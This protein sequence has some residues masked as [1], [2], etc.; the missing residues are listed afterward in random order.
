MR[1]IICSILLIV[2]ISSLGWSQCG[3]DGSYE[4]PY[5]RED[6]LKEESLT[7]RNVA[8]VDIRLTVWIVKDDNGNGALINGDVINI[9]DDVVTVFSS[10]DINISPCIKQLNDT[11]RFNS[12][13]GQER[14]YNSDCS[15][16]SFQL[17]IYED[18]AGVNTGQGEINGTTAWAIDDYGTIVHELGHLFGLKHTFNQCCP[19]DEN[20]NCL[21]P[22]GLS[23]CMEHYCSDNSSENLSDYLIDY[24]DFICDTPAIPF[25]A[26]ENTI[27][28]TD[29]DG[30]P[31]NCNCLLVAYAGE[32]CAATIY[33]DFGFKDRCG[34]EF[35]D[36]T[37]NGVV[38]NFMSYYNSCPSTFSNGQRLKM[39]HDIASFNSNKMGTFNSCDFEIVSGLLAGNIIDQ[40]LEF[41]DQ[42]INFSNSLNLINSKVVFKNCNITFDGPPLEIRSIFLTDSKI[43]LDGTSIEA[44]DDCG[45]EFLGIEAVDGGNSHIRIWNNSHLKAA[46]PIVNYGAQKLFL[47]GGDEFTIE[48]TRGTAVDAKNPML[49]FCDGGNFLGNIEYSDDDVTGYYSSY[50]LVLRD[51][52][53]THASGGGKKAGLSLGGASFALWNT[54][55]EEFDQA[56]V[57][58]EAADVVVDGCLLESRTSIQRPGVNIST[59]LTATI[60]NNHILGSGISLTEVNAM[61]EL[62]RNNLSECNGSCTEKVFLNGSNSG[63]VINHNIIDSQGNGLK[64]SGESQA[65]F[66]CNKFENSPSEN[67]NWEGVN[68]LQGYDFNI[69]SGNIFSDGTANQISGLSPD[70]VQYNYSDN[71]DEELNNYTNISIDPILVNDEA[72]CG[73]IGPSWVLSGTG[74]D[75]PDGIDCTQPCPTGIDCTMDCPAGIDCTEPCPTG[76]DCGPD[77]PLGID[78]TTYCPR[79]ID[80][81]QDCP[82]GI[83]CTQDCPAGI[84]CT[85]PCPLGVDCFVNCPPGTDCFVHCP[86]LKDCEPVVPSDD[87]I[88]ELIDQSF[89]SLEGQRNQINGRLYNTTAE[90]QLLLAD[91]V[92]E[93]RSLIDLSKRVEKSISPKDMISVIDHSRIYTKEEFIE[94]VIHNPVNLFNNKINNVIFSSK[95]FEPDDLNALTEAMNTLSSVEMSDL[96]SLKKID[97]EKDE[98]VSYALDRI[99]AY[100]KGGKKFLPLWLGRLNDL[101]SIIQQIRLDVEMNEMNNINS[102][103]SEAYRSDLSS[104]ELMD[105]ETYVALFDLL[106]SADNAGRKLD[107]LNSNELTYL[108]NLSRS[109]HKYTRAKAQSILSKFYEEDFDQNEYRMSRPDRLE[110]LQ[111]QTTDVIDYL[112][113]NV[114]IYPNPSKNELSILTD[115]PIENIMV[116]DVNGRLYHPSIDRNTINILSMLPGVYFLRFQLNGKE[117]TKKFIKI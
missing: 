11:Q 105:M 86:N 3:T 56:I 107:D 75:C 52:K 5:S 40:D 60:N 90:M 62:S 70:Q 44:A 42:T 31:D 9:I 53:L 101:E 25:P 38:T 87:P 97:Q 36:P 54:S 1:K 91:Q 20:F 7:K 111:T 102:I 79:G 95:S 17:T 8:D 50:G 103:K 73:K 27:T 47:F 57:S 21:I 23:E 63:H 24:G 96:W 66:L 114:N 94:L 34:E 55:I 29:N 88:L 84:D 92:S 30:L 4:N 113:E 14:F 74:G 67:F 12:Q 83:D 85:E 72:N 81:T 22:N 37:G 93:K 51:S 100:G 117:Y 18:Q 13:N 68:L 19:R 39:L 16:S 78:C 99:N 48:A 109:E 104:T 26:A 108:R 45:A 115:Q 46:F 49:V 35:Y 28:C 59:P 33:R 76:I 82:P 110:F 58:S 41:V 80:C 116:T 77:C 10:Y 69:A 2:L 15:E 32:N 61:Y 6:L 89:R 106:L 64:S 71:P 98:L 43:W 112:V 65:T